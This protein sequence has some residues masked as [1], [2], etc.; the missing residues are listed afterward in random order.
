MAS[1][2]FGVTPIAI[3]SF[4]ILKRRPSLFELCKRQILI[5]AS[6]ITSVFLVLY[7]FRLIPPAPLSVQFIGIY[8][9]VKKN[10]DVYEL[11]HEK[12]WWQFWNEGD[13]DFQAQPGDKIHVFF[14]IF[15]PSKFSDQVRLV[16]FHKDP[17][18]GWTPQDQIPIQI[19]GGREEG[20]RGYGL[21]SNYIPGSWRVKVETLDGREVSRIHFDL[22]LAPERP[23][24]FTLETQ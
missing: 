8:H 17:K 1:L 24:R 22:E 6:L 19:S 23:R 11:Y 2:L 13:Q 14:R 9:D 20:F 12:P 16:W 15:S 5:P 21:K 18:F 3:L 7:V 4:W 10:N